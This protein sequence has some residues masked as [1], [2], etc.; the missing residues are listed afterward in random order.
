M[1]TPLGLTSAGTFEAALSGRSAIASAPISILKLLPD[2]LAA[3]VSSDFEI[4]QTRAVAGLDRATQFALAVTQEALVDAGY[5]ATGQQKTRTGVY[6]IG[7][8]H[9]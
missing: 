6:E 4:G 8:A 3:Q 7:R 1:V 5:Q 2:A 9:V